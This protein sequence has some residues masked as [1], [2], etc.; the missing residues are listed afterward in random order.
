MEAIAPPEP[1]AGEVRIR[2]AAVSLNASDIEFLKGRP[3]YT[4][5]WGLRRP[6]FRILG[7][8]V[9]G[10]VVALG[11]DVTR[12]RVGDAVFG[13][14]MGR[15]GGLAE[16]AVAPVDAL[17]AIPDGMS[18][19]DAAAIPQASLVALQALRMGGAVRAGQR[20]LINGAG[21]GAGTFAIQIAR[22]MGAEVTAVDNGAK[23]PAMRDL[24]AVRTIDYTRTN[25][26]RTGA[27][28]D[29]IVDFIAS[30]PV[31]DYHRALAPGGRYV[32]VGGDIPHI[33]RQLT[34]GTLF[35][36]AGNRR[37]AILPA[38]PNAGI[39]DLLAM[40]AEGRVHPVIGG[41]YPLADS[42][43][44]MRELIEG[45]AIGK[46]VIDIAPS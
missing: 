6:R 2:V 21:G 28:Y 38:T 36:L 29:R 12:F 3:L 42:A 7:S 5:M 43:A 46:L 13:D 9:A 33:L 27:R 16:F 41:Q 11:P 18:F 40:I 26:L 20:V 32:M 37:M 19:S 45:R 39:E 17:T 23:A 1:G 14:I 8:D 22:A 4:R 15:W 25:P 10:T 24:G 44:A 30:H 35:S 31:R 34:L